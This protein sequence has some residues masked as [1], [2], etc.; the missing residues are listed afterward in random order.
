MLTRLSTPERWEAALAGVPAGLVVAGHTHQQDDR[1]VGDVR[2]VNAGSVGLPYEGDGAARWLWIADGEPELRQHRVR[3]RGRGRAHPRRRLAR[4]ALGR[5]RAHRPRRAARRDADLRGPGPLGLTS[6]RSTVPCVQPRARERTATG[7][8]VLASLLLVA[9]TIAGYARLAVFDSDGFADRAAAALQEP[10]VRTEVGERVTDELVLST[11]PD[12]IAG[13][14]LIVSAVSTVVSGGAFAGLF[15]RAVRDAHRAVFARDEDTVTLTLVDVGTVAGAALE[16][17]RPDLAAKLEA[18]NRVDLLSRRIGGVTGDLA[19]TAE[20]VRLLAVVLALLTLAAAGAALL[21]TADRR[22]VASRLGAGMAAAGVLV[23]IGYA[24]ARTLT[25]A[26]VSDPDARAAAAG[27]WNAFLGDLRTAGWVL[28]GAGAIVAAAAESLIR[29]VAIESRLRALGRIATTEPV[30]V[31]LRLARASALVV[32]GL[33]LIAHPQLALQ[34]V[35]TVVGVYVLYKGLEALL[36]LVYQPPAEEPAAA[37][38][39]E[40]KPR[41]R[42]SRLAAVVAIA[43]LLVVATVTAFVAGGGVEAPAQPI[44]RCNGHAALC[45]RPLDEVVLAA[46]HNSMSVPLPGWISAEQDRPIG[47][48]LEDGIHGLLLDTHYGDRL[49]NGRVRTYFGSAADLR[50]ATEQ[51]SVSPASVE[52]ALRLRGRLGFRGE[53]TRGM[54]LCHTFCELGATPLEDGLKDIHDFLA[55]HPAEVVVMVNQ[56]YVTP[57]DFVEAI[58]DADLD[59]L[60]LHAAQGLAVADAAGDDRGRPAARDAGREPRRR[61]AL[62]PARLRAPDRGDAVRLRLRGGADRRG[63]PGGRLPPEPRP[64]ARAAVPHQPLGDDRADPAPQRRREGQRLRAAA[65]ARPHLRAHPRPPADPARHQLLQGGRRL[66]GRRHPQRGR[67]GAGVALGRALAA[68]GGLDL[69]V[70]RRRVRGQAVEQLG[71]RGRDDVDGAVERLG[72]GLRRL[73]GATDL[74]DVLERGVTDLF[75]GR[76]RLEVVERA[77]V[78][79]HARRVA[80]HAARMPPIVIAHRGASGHRPEHTLAAYE[81]G[82]RQGADYIEPDLVSTRDGHLVARHENEISGT[83][84]VGG[85]AGVRGPPGDEDDRRRST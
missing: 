40:P 26:T 47:G 23:L 69:A 4:R 16:K 25:L 15:R 76:G 10:S 60:R 73:A 1:A 62:V 28:A 36:R 5:R 22:R 74:A 30:G 7:L 51:D 18:T 71:G 66:P 79:A 41:R 14:P 70:L 48:Q 54:Y 44:T 45:D 27:V 53:G 46:T 56:D 50:R 6:A 72:V 58:D 81:L 3:R 31:P 19:R 33:L 34:V 29:P 57:A 13:R 12:L 80:R 85:P 59:A 20:R 17:L 83:T 2:F 67:L 64:R 21:L 63:G 82:A 77:D 75:V 38:E 61:R 65:A 43:A 8:V 49:A 37:T 42:R 78:A 9:T 55:T 52:A 35:A 24:V 84:D 32:L 11:E 39:E 68:L